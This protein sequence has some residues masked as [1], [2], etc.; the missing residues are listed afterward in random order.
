[1]VAVVII[2]AAVY[3]NLSSNAGLLQRISG[4]GKWFLPVLIVAALTESLNPCA[5]SVLLLT[6]AFLF[7]LGR[8]RPHILKVGGVFILGIFLVYIGIGLGVLQALHLFNTPHFVA[9]LGAAIIIV[10]GVINL[11]NVFFPAFPIK[12]NIPKS[13]HR[14]MAELM[15]KG[16]VPMAFLLGAL[17]GLGEFPCTGGPYLVVL[18]LLHDNATRLAGLG[19]LLLFNVIFVVP[20]IIFLLIASEQSLLQK[21]QEW[22]RS[23]TGNMR[24]WSGVIMVVLGLIIFAL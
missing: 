15:E 20:L 16:S 17:V 4:N 8:E 13:T 3:F 11:I 19:Y 6:I 21:V 12:L 22:K 2:G 1:M 18:G 7:S 10:L 9:K 24:F 5:Y 23:E 14:K